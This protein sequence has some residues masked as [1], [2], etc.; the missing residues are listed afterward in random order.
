LREL[1]YGSG[2]VRNCKERKLKVINGFSKRP[3]IKG[4]K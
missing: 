1:G 3:E 4:E 2:Y